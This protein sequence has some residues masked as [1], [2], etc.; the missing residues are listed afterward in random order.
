[1]RSVGLHAARFIDFNDSR[2]HE[3]PCQCNTRFEDWCQLVHNCSALHRMMA[4]MTNYWRVQFLFDWWWWW[5]CCRDTGG[6]MTIF[7]LISQLRRVHSVCVLLILYAAAAATAHCEGA[8]LT[9]MRQAWW[10]ISKPINLPIDL[11]QL[12]VSHIRFIMLGEKSPHF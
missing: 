10:K 9:Y 5:W 3:N 2:P 8:S 6:M 1:M 11:L 7:I 4:M 12:P